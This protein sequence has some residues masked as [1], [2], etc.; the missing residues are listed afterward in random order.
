VNS[1]LEESTARL[2]R[3]LLS[4]ALVLLV[5]VVVAFLVLFGRVDGGLLLSLL[6]AV[7]VGRGAYLVAEA[8]RSR[9]TPADWDA[10]YRKLL[11]DFNGLP[12]RHLEAKAKSWGVASGASAA[13]LARLVVDRKR[14]RH[15]DPRPG[16]EIAAEL[17]GLVTFGLLLPLDFALYTR[18]IVSAR[19]GV[20][21]LG[22]GVAGLSL[23]LYAWPHRWERNE[24]VGDRR[25]LWWGLPVVPALALAYI[26]V[27]M[28][29]PYLDPRRP[30]RVRLR[31]ERVVS[32]SSNVE[33][34]HYTDWVVAYAAELERQGEPE[35]AADTYRRAARLAP[36][37][38][39]IRERLAALEARLGP[40]LREAAVPPRDPRSRARGIPP[41]VFAQLPFWAADGPTY[42]AP[43]CS[44]D[45]SLEEVPGTT[46]VL[47]PL[48]EV[49]IRLTNAIGDVLRSELGLPSCRARQGP[50]LPEATRIRG[51]VFG[52]QWSVEALAE[53]FV[54]WVRPAP[55]APLRFLLVTGADIYSRDSNFVFSTT[56]PWGAV[57]SY[58]RYGDLDDEWELVRHRTAKQALGALLKSFGLPPSS[59]P[60]C[61]T[62]YSNGLQQFDAKGNR[63]NAETFSKFQE[64]VEAADE[65]WRAHRA[66]L[67]SGG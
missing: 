24:G 5:I 15:I 47:V 52:R 31:A 64:R 67:G 63:P 1:S 58:A 46:V 65:R 13:Q 56:Y 43:P 12:V 41:D 4:R 19:A 17:V 38:R 25:S 66:R 29:H 32:L 30:D 22:A 7:V 59:D 20:G 60:N 49:P 16:R 34:A 6:A 37:D 40:E 11:S 57:L 51:I 10:L 39:S 48:G 44:I 61:V 53:D 14:Q 54:A 36:Q 62:S 26:G 28:H 21:Y 23:A 27:T 8:I 9:R 45:A 2:G 33:A 50:T 35:R 18:D 42:E 3:S 55:H